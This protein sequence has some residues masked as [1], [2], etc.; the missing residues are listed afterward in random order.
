MAKRR[1]Y[2]S[3]T[4]SQARPNRMYKGW[5]TRPRAAWSATRM[6]LSTPPLARTTRSLS[7]AITAAPI[8]APG[9]A[10]LADDYLGKVR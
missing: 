4:C 6:A 1:R 10:G 8:H 5:T 7:V 9:R 2:A 3:S